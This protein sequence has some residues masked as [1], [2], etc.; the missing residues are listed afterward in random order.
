MQDRIRRTSHSHVKRERIVDRF[1]RDD[2]ARSDVFFHHADQVMRRFA[3]QIVTFFARRNDRR[4]ARDGHPQNFHQAVHRVR[5]EHSGTL[6][7]YDETH[8]DR[9]FW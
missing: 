4:V 9:A 1:F 6:R 2:V 3:D 8:H 5:G 7:Q